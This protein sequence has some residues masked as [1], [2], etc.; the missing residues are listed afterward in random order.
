MYKNV[1]RMYKNVDEISL[2]TVLCGLTIL[3]QKW[4]HEAIPKAENLIVPIPHIKVICKLI[5]MS[6]RENV[7]SHKLMR[8]LTLIPCH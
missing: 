6:S 5:V 7:R 3:N 8:S 1:T 2:V 4:A